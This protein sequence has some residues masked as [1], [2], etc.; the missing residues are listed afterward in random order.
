MKLVSIP[1]DECPECLSILTYPTYTYDPDLQGE[2][3]K[4]VKKKLSNFQYNLCAYC[5]RKLSG[6]FIEHYLP[7]SSHPQNQLDWS[8]F[9]A[10]C[11]G[12]FHPKPV[13]EFCNRSRKNTPLTV[14][15]RNPD[16]IAS[17][18]FDDIRICSNDSV[19]ENDLNI[20]LNLNCKELCELREKQFKEVENIFLED[21]IE[22]GISHSEYYKK[23]I[24]YIKSTQPEFYSY[25]LDA[26]EKL[27]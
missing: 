17:I 10:V 4:E 21:A 5:E 23:I 20:L 18:Y 6:I 3:M 27:L 9:L 8:N 11:L 2:C 25:L 14:D 16:H 1:I 12:T 26:F 22:S 13:I 15:P 19:L 7:R 24:S